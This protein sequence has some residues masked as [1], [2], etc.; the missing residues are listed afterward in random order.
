MPNNMDGMMDDSYGGGD[1]AVNPPEEKP[2]ADTQSV[3]E[4]NADQ[5]DILVSKKNLPEGMKE[6]D[7]VM[8]KCMKDHGDEVSMK[9]MKDSET[10]SEPTDN[11]SAEIAALDKPENE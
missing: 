9:C 1:A 2:T 3:D 8:M 10:K 7:T 4:E 11:T 5:S 6:G